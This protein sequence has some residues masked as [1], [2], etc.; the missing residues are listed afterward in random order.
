MSKRF[1]PRLVVDHLSFRVERG[2]IT[3]FAGANGAGK[4]TTMRMLLGLVTPTS[5]EA[6]VE[7]RPYRTLS[8]PR[9]V[10]GAALDGPGAHPAHTAR[11]HLSI[12]A[13]VAGL[14]DRRVDEVLEQVGLAEHAEHRAGAFS[15]GMRQRL[16]TAG[17]LLGDPSILVLDEPINGLD[18]T[19]IL[20]MRDLLRAM[21]DEGRAVLISSHLLTELA[22]VADHMVIID[23]GRLVADAGL[24]ELLAGR[25]AHVE[26]RCAAPDRVLAALQAAGA[27]VQAD[28][29][30]LLVRGLDPTRV[31]EVVAGVD[32]GPVHHL[33]ER[34]ERFEDVF[35]SLSGAPHD[36]TAGARSL[37]EVAR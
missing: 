37:E 14:P 6:L 25:D 1:G 5:G 9:R 36:E 18:P 21:A 30:L 15:T 20:W 3:G 22:E 13:A 29:D 2:S 24:Q 31:G 23:Q 19:G 26:L 17:A 35:F 7:G 28:G 4:T 11:A 33:V 10:V 32:G 12:L 8:E 34:V 16:A 27:D